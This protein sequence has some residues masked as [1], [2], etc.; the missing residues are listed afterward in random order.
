MKKMTCAERSNSKP[1]SGMKDRPQ[2]IPVKNGGREFDGGGRKRFL[3][4]GAGVWKRE[5]EKT[6]FWRWASSEAW[7]KVGEGFS[8]RTRGKT[9]KG[10]GKRTQEDCLE[11]A[12]R[13]DKNKVPA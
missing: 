6:E 1:G 8:K 13:W 9:G 10:G 11:R 7:K 4:G 3:Y 12:T 2:K 5:G